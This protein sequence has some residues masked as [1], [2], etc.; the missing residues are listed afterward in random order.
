MDRYVIRIENE[1]NFFSQITPIGIEI[2]SDLN[3]A[4]IFQKLSLAEK[5]L[6]DINLNNFVI[7]LIEFKRISGTGN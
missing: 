1:D 6:E 5:I 2:T 3:K 4:K 7:E